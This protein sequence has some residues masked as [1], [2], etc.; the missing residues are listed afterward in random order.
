MKNAFT[1]VELLTVI[2][3]MGVLAAILFPVLASAKRSAYK[4]VSMNNMHQMGIA[5]IQ[6]M[7]QENAWSR[8]PTIESMARII[9]QDVACSPLDDWAKP[10]RF[11]PLNIDNNRPML[12]SYGYV[13]DMLRYS[14]GPLSQQGEPDSDWNQLLTSCSD[15]PLLVDPFAEGIT[16]P[17]MRHNLMSL[18]GNLFQKW[19]NMCSSEYGWKASRQLPNTS[20]LDTNGSAEISR[21]KFPAKGP[22]PLVEWGTWSSVYGATYCG[23]SY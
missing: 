2:A 5:M 7:D 23:T 21:F 16:C 13:P 22:Y 10:C 14:L 9:P 11:E 4:T 6:Y 8:P 1:L 18:G 17:W 19:F 15:V 3:I 20:Y 12:G